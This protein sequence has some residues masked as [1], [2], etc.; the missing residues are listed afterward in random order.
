MK[1]KLRMAV[2]AILLV[3]FVGSG[4]RVLYQLFQYEEGDK[5]YSEAAELVELPDFS[6]L[7]DFSLG[8]GEAGSASASAEQTQPEEVPIYVD[9]YAD[10]LRNMDFS[11][12]QEVNSDVLG[13][14]L[15]PGTNISYPV[16][17]GSDNDYYL[18]HTWKK[19][20]NSV[21]AIFLEWQNSRDLSDFN[22]IIYGHRMNNRSMFGT[23]SQYKNQSYFAQH[24]YIYITD[25]HG[26]HR[27]EVFAAY[28]V[29][30]E[31]LTY[32][33]GFS[34]DA[35]KQAFLDF[36]AGQSVIDTGVVPTVYDRVLTLSTCTG[37]G[38][39][40]RWVVQGVLR[41][42]APPDASGGG[43]ETP[44]EPEG[45]S[46]AGSGGDTPVSDGGAGGT[47]APAGSGG[48]TPVSS[49]GAGGAEAP[50]GSGA[51]DDSAGGGASGSAGSGDSAV[52]GIPGRVD[53]TGS[54]GDGAAGEAPAGEEGETP[55]TSAAAGSAGADD[56][57][58]SA[59]S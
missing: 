22:T 7:P 26:S 42:E 54:A 31:G 57:A 11:A 30:V 4:A 41:G 48:D 1:R 20:R 14:I 21:G 27:Y 34:G 39:A 29:S 36:C 46:S 53:G 58:G 32:Q 6:Q 55:D 2:I 38:H 59:V 37:N 33:L 16:V 10:A 23:L 15:V 19:T 28:E 40:T 45:D 18:N 47:E 5:T 50:A 12:L 49:G 43:T 9:P 56:P 44:G 35:S 51:G 24:P 3:V 17:Q 25:D 8:E 13:W 52:D